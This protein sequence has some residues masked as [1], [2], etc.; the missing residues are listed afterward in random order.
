LSEQIEC[1]S[2]PL[3]PWEVDAE[4][5]VA[6]AQIL[7]ECESGDDD[8]RGAVG[9]LAAHGSESVFELAVVGLDPVVGPPLDGVPCYWDQFVEHAWVDLCGIG[10]D[11]GRSHLQRGQRL[12][13]EPTGGVGVPR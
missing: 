2:D 8:G 13:E 7:Q 10:D 12:A 3:K 9:A 5:V 1:R 4:F 11:F 6:A